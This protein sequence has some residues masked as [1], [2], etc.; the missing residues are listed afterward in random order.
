MDIKLFSHKKVFYLPAVRCLIFLT[1]NTLTSSM[2]N[3]TTIITGLFLIS[4]LEV[5]PVAVSDDEAKARQFLER[6]GLLYN[7]SDYDSL[8]YYYLPAQSIFDRLQQYESSADCMLGMVD[9]H[10]MFNRQSAATRVLE[11]AEAYI[12]MHLGRES[13]SWADALFV[14]A[15]LYTGQNKNREAISLLNSSLELQE[16]LN[17]DGMG[18]ARVYNV[19]GAAYYTL[20]DLDSAEL[21]YQ[22]SFEIY[23]RIS[24]EPSV[25]KGMLLFNMG[26]VYSRRNDQHK[27]A[28]Y[29]MQGIENNISLLGPDF[30]DLAE[31]YNSLSS[32]YISAG[33]LDSARFYLNKAERI[34]INVY[35]K[36]YF[37]L[38]KIYINR[39]RI[40]KYEG[41]YQ[42]SLEYYQQAISILENQEIQQR[43]L[44][45]VAYVNLGNLYPFYDSRLLEYPDI[46]G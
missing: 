28:E 31:N 21:N 14:R 4:L 17:L 8:P 5:Y 19:L 46:H 16:S 7:S 23:M 32:Y 22:K 13:E 25:D 15:K 35:G 41:D 1:G 45:N 27:W 24:G 42:A 2:R 10:R 36:E 6:A 43:S 12:I 40:H 37:E 26:L 11:S 18:R 34:V 38:S 33:K 39:A 20:G 30:P 29:T 44:A 9:Y 3:F